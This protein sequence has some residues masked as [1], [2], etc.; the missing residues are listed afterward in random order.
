MGSHVLQRTADWSHISDGGLFYME[1]DG[2]K[3]AEEEERH[4]SDVA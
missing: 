3:Q 1:I 4:I 2:T